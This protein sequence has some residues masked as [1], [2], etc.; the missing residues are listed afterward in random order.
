[1]ILE[2]E[3]INGVAVI[4]CGNERL[5]AVIAVRFKDRFRDL[6]DTDTQNFLLDMSKI[7]F[8]D[9]SGLGAVVAV[10]KSIGR[11]RTFDL[12]GLTPTVERVFKLTRMDSVFTIYETVEQALSQIAPGPMHLSQ[13]EAS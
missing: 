10:F 11:E 1:M 13:K 6:T 3:D 9:S 8:L 12:A 5:D 4:R 7:N 2:R